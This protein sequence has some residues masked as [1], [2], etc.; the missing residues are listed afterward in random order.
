MNVE[1]YL[2]KVKI[3][4]VVTS[5]QIAADRQRCR[6]M[7]GASLLGRIQQDYFV[8]AAWGIGIVSSISMWG[9]PSQYRVRCGRLDI[10]KAHCPI[11]SAVM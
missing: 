8:A 2:W 10:E 3:D 4:K 7:T 6:I 1:L 9:E 11:D 5:E